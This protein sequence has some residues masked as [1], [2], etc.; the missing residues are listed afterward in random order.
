MRLVDACEVLGIEPSASRD[1]AQ[2]AY[3]KQALRHH[4]DRSADSDA[5]SKFQTIGEA[6]ERVQKYYESPRRWGAHADPPDAAD[7]DSSDAHGAAYTAHAS[8]EDMFAQ[9]FGGSGGGTARSS[10]YADFQPP[11]QHKAGCK[12]AACDA[13]RRREAIFAQRARERERRRREQ[14]RMMDGVRQVIASIA[15]D[16]F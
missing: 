5:T 16:C 12:C 9:W 6:W 11:Q 14:E 2:K 7:D 10:S 8:W 1:D 4:P 3:R 15:S 13:E